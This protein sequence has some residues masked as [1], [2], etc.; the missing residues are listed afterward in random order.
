MVSNNSGLSSQ[1]YTCIILNGSGSA[2]STLINRQAT[3]S[4]TAVQLSVLTIIESVTNCTIFNDP[5]SAGYVD[6]S[7]HTKFRGHLHT[8]A[9]M[10]MES[11]SCSVS[12]QKHVVAS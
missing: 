5:S 7:V 9:H 8:L 2:P 10:R 12:T 3:V 11:E 1:L 6:H 4:S